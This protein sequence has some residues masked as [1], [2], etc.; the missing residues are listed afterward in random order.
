M[1]SLVPSC[2]PGF[3]FKSSFHSFVPKYTNPEIPV[4]IPRER[5]EL[6]L[7]LSGPR[8]VDLAPWFG[9][10]LT[11]ASETLL[12]PLFVRVCFCP[13]AERLEIDTTRL[14]LA[15]PLSTCSD[16]HICPTTFCLW[17]N[18]AFSFA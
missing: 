14:E 15:F 1:T 17:H 9:V 4:V 11:Q 13:I 7:F 12:F 5:P 8:V 18:D 3:A 16:I 6:R 10:F 2:I